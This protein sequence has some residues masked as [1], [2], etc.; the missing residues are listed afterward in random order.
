MRSHY[1]H[2]DF[3]IIYRK[4]LDSFIIK[5]LKHSVLSHGSIKCFCCCKSI[6]MYVTTPSAIHKLPNRLD[7]TVTIDLDTIILRIYNI[8]MN[9]S[10]G[11]P[12]V[13]TL[14]RFPDISIIGS[15][16]RNGHHFWI[17]SWFLKTSIL[18]WI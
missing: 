13:Y 5:L 8:F 14:S 17:W 12:R 18:L 10:L 2:E 9:I 7:N 4:F 3:S 15:A 1:C 6:N 16:Q 11:V